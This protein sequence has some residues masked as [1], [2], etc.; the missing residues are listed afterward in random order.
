MAALLGSGAIEL[1]DSSTKNQ[2]ILV[3]S[4]KWPLTVKQVYSLMKKEFFTA[5][6]Y[7]A[8][9]KVLLGLEKQKVVS[10]IGS[11]WQLEQN[12]LQKQET[13]FQQ[14][15]QKYGG[16][17]NRY[18]IEE[19]FEGTQNFEFDS[20][21]DL[22]VETAKLLT[23][24]NLTQKAES[25]YCILEY[26]WCTIKFKFEHFGLIF[27]MLKKCPNARY[28]I[29]KK[30]RFGEWIW[31]QYRRAG[32]IGAPIGTKIKIQEDIFVQG[33]YI[34]QIKISNPG[35]K[36]IRKYWKKWKNIEDTFKDL[37]LKPEPKIECKVKITKNPELAN[38]IKQ[39][40]DKYFKN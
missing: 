16:A 34:I 29:R 26:G 24:K 19:N 23:S 36:I 37:G 21:S 20:F 30:T 5:V 2:I 11:A 4:R 15:V 12:W 1:G 7:Q 9:H 27:G 40:L 35:K 22:C 8:V 6:S 3:L 13:F 39:E 33:D 10:R 32:G 17:K 28:I 25:F 31:K 38:F 14:A 18:L